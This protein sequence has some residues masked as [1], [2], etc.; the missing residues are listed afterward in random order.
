MLGGKP[1]RLCRFPKKELV[2]ID[3]LLPKDVLNDFFRNPPSPLPKGA[4]PQLIL[5]P[6]PPS[7]G[8]NHQHPYSLLV[9]KKGPQ[10]SPQT[11]Q[12]LAYCLPLSR[13]GIARMRFGSP[14]AAPSVPGQGLNTENCGNRQFSSVLVSRDTRYLFYRLARSLWGVAR[15]SLTSEP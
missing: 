10:P 15:R 7:K 4:P 11:P 6:E 1:A 5:P 12:P 3:G 2:I 13:L 8:V 14:L 9:L